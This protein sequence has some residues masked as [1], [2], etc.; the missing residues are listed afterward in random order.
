MTRVSMACEQALAIL[1]GEG[2]TSR[3]ERIRAR[4][5]ASRC[6]RCSGAYD[7]AGRDDP[8]GG[9]DADRLQ[10]AAWL[11]IGLGVIAAVQLVLAGPWLFGHSIIPDP[12]VAVAHLTR[13]GALG[14][15]IGSLGLLTAWRPRYAYSTLLVGVLVLTLQVVSGLTDHDAT[16]ASE[17]FELIHL[18]VVTIVC[19]MLAVAVDVRR[20]ATPM[21]EPTSPFL[22][23]RR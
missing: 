11:R 23:V 3:D 20:R 22:R 4:A 13:D 18:L 10:P 17:S 14:L 2:H 15:V 16:A 8:L 19:G 12:H 21:R 7:T 6:P 1:T 9:F 5:H